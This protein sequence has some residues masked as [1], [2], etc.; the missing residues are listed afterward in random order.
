M[1]SGNVR[2]EANLLF[3]F[4]SAIAGAFVLGLPMALA[5]I[6]LLKSGASI[7]ELDNCPVNR[8]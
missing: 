7:T 2:P 3:A 5:I 4:T 8:D 6:W 1:S